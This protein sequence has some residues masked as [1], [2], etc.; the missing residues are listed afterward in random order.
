MNL[1][2]YDD[3]REYVDK[4]KTWIIPRSQVLSTH[5]IKYR[6][7]SC[8]LKRYNDKTDSYS[9]FIAMSDTKIP[10]RNSNHNYYN[11][12]GRL[13]ISLKDIWNTSSLMNVSQECNT[14][15]KLVE[16]QDDGEIYQLLDI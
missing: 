6:P 2:C 11:P 10:N 4:T 12:G 13:R 9:Y 8:L 14:R 5:E 15:I 16:T 1:N 3:A 7:W